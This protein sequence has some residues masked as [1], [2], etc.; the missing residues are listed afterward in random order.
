MASD[1]LQL[2]VQQRTV[3]G[4]KVKARRRAGLIPGNIVM[5]GK[6]SLAVEI[7]LA[8]LIKIIEQAG[9]TQALELLIDQKHKITALINSISYETTRDQPQHIIF[10][11]IKKGETVS[12]SVPLT[13]S[14]EAP[15]TQKGLIV[16]QM[17]YNLEVKAPALSIPEQLEVDISQLE[18]NG[19]VVRVSQISLPSAVEIEIDP[20]TPIVRLEI[21]RSQVSQAAEEATEA[22]TPAADGDDQAPTEAAVDKKEAE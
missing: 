19:D 6:A 1:L 3:L 20:Q 21:S 22:E 17:L 9:Y 11:E 14:G 2:A 5:K 8:A 12:A 18:D 15:G 10:F 13:L 4:K 7:P 16:L